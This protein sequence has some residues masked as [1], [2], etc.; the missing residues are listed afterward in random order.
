MR[1]HGDLQGPLLTADIE[2]RFVNESQQ[3]I[4]A[5]YT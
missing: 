1:L 2:Q 5:V 4:E 3:A